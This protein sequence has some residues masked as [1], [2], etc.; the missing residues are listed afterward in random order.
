MASTEKK[1]GKND[2]MSNTNGKLIALKR[3]KYKQ[4]I[5]LLLQCQAF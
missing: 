3:K 1:L 2:A 4:V 5:F